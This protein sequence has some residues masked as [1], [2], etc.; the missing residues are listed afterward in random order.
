MRTFERSLKLCVALLILPFATGCVSASKTG[1]DI[2]VR[3]PYPTNPPV[4]TRDG[5]DAATDREVVDLL[6]WWETHCEL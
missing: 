6:I 4:H 5:Q 1:G 2:C 3:Y